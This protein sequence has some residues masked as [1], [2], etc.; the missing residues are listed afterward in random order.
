VIGSDAGCG[1]YMH[2]W[3]P[4]EQ[5]LAGYSRA[6]ESIDPAEHS[7]CVFAALYRNVVERLRG[8]GHYLCSWAPFLL[9][10]IE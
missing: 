6:D 3:P 5:P 4:P 8:E 9:P 1:E 10:N 7:K 2:R